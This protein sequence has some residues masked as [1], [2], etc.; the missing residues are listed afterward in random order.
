MHLQKSKRVRLRGLGPV[1]RETVATWI[2]SKYA[3]VPETIAKLEMW[4][5]DH[6]EDKRAANELTNWRAAQSVARQLA[7]LARTELS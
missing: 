5:R 6:P 4:L 1:E 3:H 2:E 7:H